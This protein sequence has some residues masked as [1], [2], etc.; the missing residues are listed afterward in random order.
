MTSDREFGHLE[1]AL[2]A[3]VLSGC[4]WEAAALLSKGRLPTVSRI[5]RRW[6]VFGS[7]VLTVLEVH[8][9]PVKLLP[10]ST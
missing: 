5:S 6:P 1:P 2:K 8:F 9:R 3:I 7:A 10:P 4:L